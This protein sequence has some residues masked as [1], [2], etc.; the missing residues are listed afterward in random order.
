MIIVMITLSG[1]FGYKSL[2]VDVRSAADI[3]DGIL[4][5]GLDLRHLLKQTLLLVLS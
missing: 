2:P 3:D 4:N 5:I 1:V